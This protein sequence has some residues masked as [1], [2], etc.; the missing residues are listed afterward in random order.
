VNRSV[1]FLLENIRDSAHK[2]TELNCSVYIW[3]QNMTL[4]RIAIALGFLAGPAMAYTVDLPR[5][6]WPTD[7]T[8]PVTQGCA[9]PTS[10]GITTTCGGK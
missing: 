6:N 2:V 7:T 4:L 9:N 8:P 5:L 3:M 10:I 1:Y